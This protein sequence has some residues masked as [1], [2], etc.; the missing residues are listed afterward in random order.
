[1]RPV[2]MCSYCTLFDVTS[3]HN[4]VC[5][6]EEQHLQEYLA[7]KHRSAAETGHVTRKLNSG[8]KIWVTVV[9]FSLRCYVTLK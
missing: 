1:M 3:V 9:Q 6:K 8:Y 4:G 5:V 7:G 2:I